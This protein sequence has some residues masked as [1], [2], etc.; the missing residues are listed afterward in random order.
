MSRLD[1][2]ANPEKSNT[3]G[4]EI[5]L[6]T[7]K[8]TFHRIQKAGVNFTGGASALQ[9]DL[10]KGRTE[11]RMTIYVVRLNN[12]LTVDRNKHDHMTTDET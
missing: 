1:I 6:V 2:Y 11:K 3:Q 10:E 8:G 12:A 4:V 9:T 7:I 5:H